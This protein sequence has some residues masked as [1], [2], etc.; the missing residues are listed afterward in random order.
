METLKDM[1]KFI[2]NL[3]SKT[4]YFLAALASLVGFFVVFIN[5]KDKVLWSFI[6]FNFLLL[7]LIGSAIYT[8]LRLLNKSTLDFESKST[9]I[10]YETLDGNNI[11]YEVYKLIQCKRPILSE[12]NY[13]FKWSGTNQPKIHSDLQTVID[14]MD[15]NNPSNYDKAILKLKKPLIFNES[16]VIHFKADLDDSDKQS[17]TYVSNRIIRPVDVIHYRILLRH[18][19]DNPNAI[20]ERKKIDA[21][22]Q[23][24]DK[25][26]EVP[27]DKTSKS[28]EHPLLNP[29]LGYI[30]RISWD[31]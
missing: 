29:E 24:F 28:Y 3:L 2:V 13:S 21:V 17:G 19:D 18:K 12:Y 31:R 22:S 27:F 30:Y 11:S 16:C 26:K 8:I 23:A 9:F 1:F 4:F 25:V 15:F 20:I 10:K 5:D 6:F 14:V 7:V